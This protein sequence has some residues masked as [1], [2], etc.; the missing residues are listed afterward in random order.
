MVYAMWQS[1]ALERTIP[2]SQPFKLEN[3]LTR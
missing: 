3:L 2:V 1:D